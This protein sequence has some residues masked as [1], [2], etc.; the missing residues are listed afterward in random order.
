MSKGL[1]TTG[2]VVAGGIVVAAIWSIT[3]SGGNAV[4]SD[5]APGP[6]LAKTR[7]VP[8]G[9]APV[10]RATGFDY[11]NMA[12]DSRMPRSGEDFRARFAEMRAKWDL[13]GDGELSREERQLMFE[14]MQAERAAERLAEFDL[15]G[16]G[17]LNE[18]EERAARLAD[19]LSN[20]RGQELAKE[21]DANGDGILDAAEVAAMEADMQRRRDER[22]QARI[23]RDDLNGDG[24]VDDIEQEIAREVRRARM[25]DFRDTMT[26]SYDTDGDGELS[27]DERSAAFTDLRSLWEQSRFVSANDSNGDGIVDNLDMSSFIDRFTNQDPSADLNGDGVFDSSDLDEYN[28]RIDQGENTMP[29]EDELPPMGGFRGGFGGGAHGGGSGGGGRGGGGG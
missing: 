26:T 29:S 27:P 24:V 17:V 20:P 1:I 12:S 11:L 13:D 15:D 5:G 25:E 18:E 22:D 2:S 21:F 3:A 28:R 7:L 19:L 4:P 10:A 23:A 8:T 9:G 16:D 14:A 6:E